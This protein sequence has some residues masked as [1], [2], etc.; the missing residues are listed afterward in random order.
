MFI[1]LSFVL[2]VTEHLFHYAVGILGVMGI[3]YWLRQVFR[4]KGLPRPE[5]DLVRVTMLFLCVF[6]PMAL[7]LPDAVN[8]RHAT[9]TTMSYLHFL[10]AALYVCVI[11]R[12]PS[13]RNFI[14]NCLCWLLA[15]LVI[16]ALVQ[17]F[18][19]HNLLGYPR[20]TAV[21]TG[22]FDNNQ[23]LGLVL[24]LFLPLILF[25]LHR[26]ERFGGW[27][28][29][30]LIPYA[31]VILV[32]LKRSAWVMLVVGLF[33]YGIL[34]IRNL[35]MDWRMKLLVPLAVIVVIASSA[36]FIPTVGERLQTTFGALSADYETLDIA[37]SRRLTLWAT[38]SEMFLAHPING[39]GPR[40]YRYAYKQFAAEDD[41][42]IKQN[43]KGQTHPHL[44]GLEVLTETGILGFIGLA[45]FFWVLVRAMFAKRRSDPQGA[46]WLALAVVAWFPLNSHLAFYGSYWSTFA[47][48]FIAIGMANGRDSGHF[49]FR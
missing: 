47:W 49:L 19:G 23:R 33:L 43:G 45:V 48:L 15:L 44:M 28:W 20:D 24:A 39:V 10:P 36:H 38:G 6:L 34:F 26:L 40:G 17:F 22:M 30:L 7:T 2:M 12:V 37:S 3:T 25:S 1:V 35:R 41:F 27:Q 29:L 4:A 16:D 18:L 11:C 32:S 9:K 5:S 8:P 14:G 42:W 13:S 31:V 46:M 21:L